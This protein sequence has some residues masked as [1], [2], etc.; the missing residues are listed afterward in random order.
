MTIEDSV[1]SGVTVAKVAFPRSPLEA[2]SIDVYVAFKQWLVVGWFHQSLRC[3]FAADRMLSIFQLV[4]KFW[5][6]SAKSSVHF[7]DPG[8]S[9]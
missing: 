5:E 1:A 8:G 2:C 7:E 3:S 9:N 6:T 4:L